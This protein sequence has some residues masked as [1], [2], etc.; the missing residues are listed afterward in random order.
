MPALFEIW[1]PDISRW[2]VWASEK[3]KYWPGGL[4]SAPG[5]RASAY[6]EGCPHRQPVVS[7]S[8]CFVCTLTFF[9][10]ILSI[11]RNNAMNENGEMFA[12]LCSF[13]RLII[14]GSVFPHRRIHK[15]T[16]VSP[17][18][19]T[20]SDRP[21]LYKSEI[22]EIDARCKSTQRGRCSLRSPPS[23]DKTE[24]ETEEQS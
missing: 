8:A 2:P 1:W 11:I 9:A 7:Y 23:A 20:E 6:V 12:D 13:N 15:A 3:K 14:G 5:Q 10:L 21:Y 4:K 16:W 22:Q 24:V 18:H 17:D 19:Q